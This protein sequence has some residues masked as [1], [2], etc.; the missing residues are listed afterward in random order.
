VVCEEA[1]EGIILMKNTQ[2]K[3][4][5]FEKLDYVEAAVDKKITFE[6]AVL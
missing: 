1:S 6:T 3:V 2:G 5:G 4:I